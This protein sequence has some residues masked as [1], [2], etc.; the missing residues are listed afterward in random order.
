MCWMPGGERA[1]EKPLQPLLGTLAV[2]WGG[3]Q[4]CSEGPTAL[5]SG[6]GGG[7]GVLS[8]LCRTNLC[9]KGLRQERGGIYT[10]QVCRGSSPIE[11]NWMA[12]MSKIKWM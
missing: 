8:A 10:L 12:H 5:S 4:L 3:T 1:E 11:A 6:G 2:I 7:G 9:W